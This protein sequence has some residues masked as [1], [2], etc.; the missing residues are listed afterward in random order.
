[1]NK[2]QMFC[3]HKFIPNSMITTVACIAMVGCSLITIDVL[4]LDFPY[5]AMLERRDIG[6]EWITTGSGTSN[7]YDSVDTFS[8]SFRYRSE[9]DLANSL[10]AHVLYVYPN[11][12][13][14][15]SGFKYLEEEYFTG[16]YR[17]ELP[18]V[19]IY[20]RDASDN[21]RLG[22]KEKLMNNQPRTSCTYL[23]QHDKYVWL[24]LANLDEEV[25]TMNDL[26]RILKRL[27]WKIYRLEESIDEAA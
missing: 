15:N 6:D 24:I 21:T 7:D 19:L 18:E 1:M 23:H 4:P 9:E 5:E 11:E 25:I 10:I 13:D 26:I 16:S 8:V 2:L 20:P 27:E 22:C 17:S 14:A 3:I 12:E